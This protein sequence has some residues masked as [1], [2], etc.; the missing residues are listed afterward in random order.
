[1][2]NFFIQLNT[3]NL[4]ILD[5]FLFSFLCVG[6]VTT[7]LHVGVLYLERFCCTDIFNPKSL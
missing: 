1:M 4:R 2:L 6:G 5:I 7:C 3:I